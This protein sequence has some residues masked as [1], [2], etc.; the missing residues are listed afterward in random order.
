MSFAHFHERGL[1][2]P[3]SK[4]FWGLLHHYGI[5]LQNLNPNAVLQMSIFVALSKGYLGIRTH[6]KL[7]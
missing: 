7:S 5:E 6:F 3:S 1:G 4:F 2:T